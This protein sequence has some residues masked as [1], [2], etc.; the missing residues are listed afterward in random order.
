LITKAL[1]ANREYICTETQANSLEILEISG[2]DQILE[3]DELSVNFDI[4]KS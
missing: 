4:V 3:L 1:E 2:L